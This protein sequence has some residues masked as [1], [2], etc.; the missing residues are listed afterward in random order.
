M[1]FLLHKHT[2]EGVCDDFPKIF[3]NFSEGQMNVPEH[4]TRISKNV[5]RS[6]K[7]A[8]DFQGRSEDVLMIHQ[9]I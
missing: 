1:F 4:F 3:H 6:P 9:Q 8:E 7:V 2:D 5:W